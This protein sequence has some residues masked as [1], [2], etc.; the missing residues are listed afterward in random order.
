VSGG[1]ATI[2]FVDENLLGRNI[3]EIL[4]KAGANVELLSDHL[5][6]QTSDVEWLT[7]VSQRNWIVL[8]RD[9]SIGINIPEVVAVAQGNA[10]MFALAMGNSPWDEIERDLA[11]AIPKMKRFASSH[12]APFIA[13]VYPYAKIK[14]WLD[15]KRLLKTLRQYAPD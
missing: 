12:K 4:Q 6:M 2:F 11:I 8:S 9:L 1:E 10:K 13:R 5:P 14:M 15:R 7:E 3:A